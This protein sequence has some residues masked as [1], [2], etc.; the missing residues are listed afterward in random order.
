MTGMFLQTSCSITKASKA[1]PE[2]DGKS[3]SVSIRSMFCDFSFRVSHAAK[4][5][6][7]AT[8][9][10]NQKTR[11]E[12]NN[13]TDQTYLQNQDRNGNLTIPKTDKGNE[14]I[15]QST[16]VTAF[17]KKSSDDLSS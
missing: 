6:E 13:F 10:S 5:S 15:D 4:P 14:E 17:P 11:I 3:S 7:T 12:F 9:V 8:T 16:F 1:K 2:I